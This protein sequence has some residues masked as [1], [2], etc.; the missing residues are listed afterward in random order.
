M[1]FLSFA[2]TFVMGGCFGLVG[3][4]GGADGTGGGG[5][6]GELTT[7]STSSTTGGAGGTGGTA[8]KPE[9]GYVGRSCAADSECGPAGRCIN[10]DQYDSTFGGKPVGGYCTVNCEADEDCPDVGSYCSIEVGEGQCLLGCAWNEPAF[11]YGETPLDP[12]KCH[13]REDLM[14]QPI[15]GDKYVCMPNCGRDENCPA[16]HYCHPLGGSCV[17]TPPEGKAFGEEC[18]IGSTECAGHCLRVKG[19][20][21]QTLCTSLC[22]L[23]GLFEES[24]DCGG[25]E[26]GWCIGRGT[27]GGGLGDRGY[28]VPSCLAQEDCRAPDFFCVGLLPA[29]TGLCMPAVVC[30]VDADCQIPGTNCADTTMGKFCLTLDYPL[31]G[32]AP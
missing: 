15:I 12:T 13:G 20:E 7:S 25:I 4:D 22:T 5:A 6:G 16:N 24:D 31:G 18:T 26:E 27:S 1:R 29:S 21:Q 11:E 3:C 17:D 8:P 30:T 9:P 19:T 14:C 23:G 28:C 10:S 32:L 2:M